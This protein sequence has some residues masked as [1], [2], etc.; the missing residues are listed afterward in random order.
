MRAT[1][2]PKGARAIK[3]ILSSV[4]AAT[5]EPGGAGPGNNQDGFATAG[6]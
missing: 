2:S 3:S 5:E 6:L 4:A 1:L